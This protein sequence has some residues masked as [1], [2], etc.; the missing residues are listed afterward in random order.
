MRRRPSATSVRENRSRKRFL[1]FTKAARGQIY[2]PCF[3]T[4]Q[5]R[6]TIFRLVL[7]FHFLDL[8][9]LISLSLPTPFRSCFLCHIFTT[10]RRRTSLLHLGFIFVSG[11]NQRVFIHEV[12]FALLGAGQ[13]RGWLVV[14]PSSEDAQT[15]MVK[16]CPHRPNQI[17]I[18][19]RWPQEYTGRFTSCYHFVHTWTVFLALNYWHLGTPS[20]DLCCAILV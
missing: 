18:L 1:R 11:K 10:G 15:T 9:R 14:Q 13:G 20:L 17:Y 16:Q 4:T 12:L 8:S 7:S 2:H 5:M 3:K 6:A 19:L